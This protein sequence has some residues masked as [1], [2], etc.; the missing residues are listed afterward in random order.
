[1]SVVVTNQS[2]DRVV[3]PGQQASGRGDGVNAPSAVR[4][5]DNLGNPINLNGDAFSD[6]VVAN[7]GGNNVLVYLGTAGGQFD[8]AHPVAFSAGTD[9]VD[10]QVADINGDGRQDVIATNFGSNDVSILVGTSDVGT[11]GNPAMLRPGERLD[12][13]QGPASTQVVLQE[14][15]TN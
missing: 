11:D 2:Q 14:G 9:P 15:H 1:N 3:V 5:T 12:V 6:M 10:V 8:L 13:G 7:S 4:L